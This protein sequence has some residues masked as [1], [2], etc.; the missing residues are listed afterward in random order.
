[1][2]A[3]CPRLPALEDVLGV[4]GATLPTSR[5]P[6]GTDSGQKGKRERDLRAPPSVPPAVGCPRSAL[7]SWPAMWGRGI[8]SPLTGGKADAPHSGKRLRIPRRRFGWAGIR[9]WLL[10]SPELRTLLLLGPGASHG[11]PLV[12]AFLHWGS[13]WGEESVWTALSS[14]ARGPVPRGRISGRTWG[15]G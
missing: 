10:L 13:G 3:V 15:S 5:P 1:M 6:R 8:T 4:H 9:T 2:S 14:S 7:S 12:T 11:H